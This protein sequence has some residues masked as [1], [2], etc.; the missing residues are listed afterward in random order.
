MCLVGCNCF[1][2]FIAAVCSLFVQ[3]TY[4]VLKTFHCDF[5]KTDVVGILWLQTIVSVFA[6][7]YVC[8]PGLKMV[9]KIIYLHFLPTILLLCLSTYVSFYFLYLETECNI[10]GHDMKTLLNA[11]YFAQGVV[12]V[13]S[14]LIFS[15]DLRKSC[16]RKTNTT[17]KKI[18]EFRQFRDYEDE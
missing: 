13:V 12:P 14:I 15:N 5:G 17:T 16:S 9:T 1:S 11:M 2:F 6:C 7:I 3:V 10:Y 4:I 18:N 8:L